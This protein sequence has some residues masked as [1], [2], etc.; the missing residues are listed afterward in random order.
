MKFIRIVLTTVLLL[1]ITSC[2]KELDIK[3]HDIPPITV[4]EGELTPDGI[5]VGITQTTPMDEPMDRTRLTDASVTLTDLSSETTLTLTANADGYFMNPT[6]GITGHRYRLTVI[7][8]GKVYEAETT[9]YPPSQFISLGFN[10]IK[11]P[12]DHVAV[13][14]AQ[15]RDN[16]DSDDYYWIKIFRNG[17]IYQWDGMND[18]GN[19]DGILTFVTMTSRKDTDEEDESSVLYDGD[20]MTVSIS[21]ISRE[22]YE[23]VKE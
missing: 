12:Y 2:E 4:I 20:L 3:Y 22:M 15:F 23:Y 18:S 1:F 6:G 13:L 21:A 17:K 7:R 14:Q 16:S 9:M 10:W 8:D 19:V 5:K 11:M